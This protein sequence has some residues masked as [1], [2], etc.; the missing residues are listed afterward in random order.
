MGRFVILHQLGAGGMG[1]V[2]AA[3]DEKLNRKVALKLLHGHLGAPEHQR[4]RVLREAKALARVTHP[5][6]VTVY[7]VGESDEQVYLAMEF[8]DGMTLR[9]WQSAKV[10]PWYDALSMYLHVGA[11]L[12]AA[13][14]SG[15]VHRDFKPDN[16]LV[17]KDE[18]PRVADFGIARMETS[19]ADHFE[20]NAELEAK[21]DGTLGGNVMGT[22]GYM[23]PEHHDGS[24]V[25]AKSDQW[26]YCA[27]LFEG[28]YGYLPFSGATMSEHAA[29]I[30]GPI[31][32]PPADS[33][34]PSEIFRIVKRGLSVDPSA[35]YPNMQA[36]L[37]NLTTEQTSSAAAG[38]SSRRMLV[39]AMA[40]ATFG[41]FLLLQYL[42]GHRA[43]IVSY[44][45]MLSVGLVTVTIIAGFRNRQTLRRNL[46][47]RTMWTL[48]LVTFVQNLIVRAIF[49]FRGPWPA[50]LEFAIEMLVWSGTCLTITMTLIQR[51][52]WVILVPFLAGFAAIIS[53]S[54]PRRLLLCVYPITVGLVLWHWQTAARSRKD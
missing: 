34:V 12:H 10:R 26:S 2:Y 50:Q 24:R 36:L 40:L 6:V 45:F 48:I 37:D 17:G 33:N 1:A 42:L 9:Q 41:T 28:L 13:H 46:F 31:R 15:I 25:D 20:G 35:R 27:A 16:V 14:Q 19:S 39:A 53:E 22:P 18:L 54:P 30:R 49:T 5:R 29:N 32:M 44:A 52:W 3:Y 38:A 23:S 7:D 11:G 43:R 51:M 4:A 47:H 21:H 8:V